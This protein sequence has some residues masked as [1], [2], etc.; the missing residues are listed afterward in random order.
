MVEEGKQP[1]QSLAEYYKFEHMEQCKA[2]CGLE[3]MFY[4]SN[5]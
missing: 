3:V 5:P 4:C 2:G 1:Q